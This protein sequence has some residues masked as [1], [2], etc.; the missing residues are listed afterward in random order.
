MTGALEHDLT[1]MLN[2]WGMRLASTASWAG[3]NDV[4]A[5]R[6]GI[7]L[8]RRDVV[9]CMLAARDKAEPETRDARRQSDEVEVSA[10]LTP[11][12]QLVMSVAMH[13]MCNSDPMRAVHL[14]TALPFWL[15]K[16]RNAN[17]LKP[18]AKP[19]GPMGEAC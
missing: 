8:A 6:M 7:D 17:T 10:L 12:E 3:N 16:L 1:E 5:Y 13:Q 4:D 14:S 9:M 18:E 2:I 19:Q 15:D 11:C